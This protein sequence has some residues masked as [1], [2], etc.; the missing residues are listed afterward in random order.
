[1]SVLSKYNKGSLF[2]FKL[3][4]EME[5]EFIKLGEL[6]LKKRYVVLMLYINTKGQYKDHPVA[7]TYPEGD[8]DALMMVDLPEHLTETV[9]EMIV[10]QEIA[11][12]A[13]NNK[14]AFEIRTYEYE[15]GEKK[16]VKKTGYSVQWVEL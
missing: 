6:D 8:A 1:M 5:M 12:L 9:R 10:D 2:S 7:V 3:D 11:E 16:K 14:L 13:N 4:P 15:S